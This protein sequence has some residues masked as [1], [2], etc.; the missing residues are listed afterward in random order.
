MMMMMMMMMMRDDSL[1]AVR[2]VY[3]I[4]VI[5]RTINSQHVPNGMSKTTMKIRKWLHVVLRV[6]YNLLRHTRLERFVLKQ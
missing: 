2:K 1:N 5:H 4:Y 6:L 3:V